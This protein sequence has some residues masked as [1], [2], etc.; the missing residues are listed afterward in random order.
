PQPPASRRRFTVG[1]DILLLREVVALNPFADPARWT[2]LIE[3]LNAA[4]GKAYTVRAARERCDLLLG[5]FR[6][7]DRTNLRKSGTEEQYSEKEHLLQEI[8]DMARES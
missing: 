3:N 5:H 8:S 7:E 4:T 6:R 1:D 2:T